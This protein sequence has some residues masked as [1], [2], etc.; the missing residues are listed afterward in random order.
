MIP[1]CYSLK[2]TKKWLTRSQSQKYPKEKLQ[3]LELK[4][5]LRSNK[6]HPKTCKNKRH[7]KKKIQLELIIH[8][9]T[10]TKLKY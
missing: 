9:I 6:I 4:K 1:T 7:P 10:S 3:N 8:E 5:T 2:E